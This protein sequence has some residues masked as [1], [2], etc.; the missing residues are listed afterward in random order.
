LST[1]TATPT[2]IPWA[3][4]S[5]NLVGSVIDSSVSLL[6]RQTHDIVSFAIGSPASEAIP[7]DAFGKIY[8]SVLARAG[9]SAFGYAAT[10]GDSELLS[11]LHAYLEGT[12]ERTTADRLLITSGGMQGL[13]LA[14]KLFVDPGDLVIVEAPT[15]TNGA[16]TLLAYGADILEAPIDSHGLIVEA[17]PELVERAGRRPKAI[18]VIPNFQNP[19][20][21]A[22]SLERRRL[23]L[24][25]ARE[26]GSIIIDDDPYGMLRFDGEHIPGFRELGGRDP[27]VFSVRTFSKI[28]APGLRIG[29]IDAD[30]VII[31]KL[32]DAKQTMDTCTN[33]PNQLLVAEFLRSGA[34]EPHLEGLRTEYRR[35]MEAMHDSLDRHLGG[36]ATWTHPEGGFFLWVT[37]AADVD[38]SRLFEIGVRNG[39]AFIPGGAF[40][41]TGQF[42]NALRLSFAS[43]TPERM[44]VGITRLADALKAL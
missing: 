16:A 39:V 18:Y 3:T 30:P 10:E 34:I 24:V 1:S 33:V 31:S 21:T 19:T 15:Y 38:T 6:Q 37:F 26:W 5:E 9:A 22:M 2:N 11:E 12:P 27:L 41:V 20:G 23:L 36:R 8:E 4:R 13:D 32:I 7:S 14:A 44:E 40:S 43:Q 25:L 28:L 42:G 17:L 29:W 35:R